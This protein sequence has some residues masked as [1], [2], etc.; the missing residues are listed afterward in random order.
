M[1]ATRTALDVAAQNVANSQTPG[2]VRQRV[3]LAPVS[4][5]ETAGRVGVGNGVTVQTIQRR[6]DQCLEAQINH[7]EGELGRE[8]SRADSL[9][10]VETSFTDLSQTG[11]STA[12]GNFFDSLQS[13]QTAPTSVAARD[14]VIYAAES[15]ATKTNEV[16]GQLSQ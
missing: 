14:E 5:A 11:L 9:S 8:S 3:S 15:L 1:A 10:R 7:Q 12:L 16:A 2:Y 13:L 6:R 4:G